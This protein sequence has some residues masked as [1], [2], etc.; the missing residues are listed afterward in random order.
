MLEITFL[1]KCIWKPEMNIDHIKHFELNVYSKESKSVSGRWVCGWSGNLSLSSLHAHNESRQLVIINK[2]FWMLTWKPEKKESCKPHERCDRIWLL[3]FSSCSGG[4]FL[5]R[6]MLGN[7]AG[8]RE[9]HRD[10]LSIQI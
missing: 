2:N 1:S 8:I 7:T 5:R 3:T 9:S 4:C 10:C 6:L